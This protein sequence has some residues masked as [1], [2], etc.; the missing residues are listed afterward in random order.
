MYKQPIYR[1]ENN[2]QYNL[3]NHPM[4]WKYENEERNK[5]ENNEEKEIKIDENAIKFLQG[6]ASDILDMIP[7]VSNIKSGLEAIL[8]KNIITGEDLDLIERGLK[9]VGV[10]PSGNVL[11]KIVKSAKGRK[12]VDKILAKK[13]KLQEIGEEYKKKKKEL[14][15]IIELKEKLED[16]IDG[17]DSNDSSYNE[18]D[19]YE[20]DDEY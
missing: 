6:V 5:K 3:C 14:K 2:I 10:I 16:I 7:I 1:F 18:D 19:D 9:L 15:K 8:G 12:I 4:E 17:N 20:D 11:Y 13:K